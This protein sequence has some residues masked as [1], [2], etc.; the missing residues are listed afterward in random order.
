MACKSVPYILFSSERIFLVIHEL[1]G[2]LQTSASADLWV[3]NTRTIIKLVV[4]TYMKKQVLS[5]QVVL[6]LV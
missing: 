1:K 5:V 6:P 3:G 4:L 2:S